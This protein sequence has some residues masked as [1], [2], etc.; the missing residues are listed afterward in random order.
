MEWAVTELDAW[1][2]DLKKNSTD[3]LT[4][5]FQLTEEQWVVHLLS[6]P[7][8][9][10]QPLPYTPS[11][12]RT[13]NTFHPRFTIPH[14]WTPGVCLRAPFRIVR[15]PIAVA[16]LPWAL[17]KLPPLDPPP[18][19]PPQQRHRVVWSAAMASM[20]PRL[21]IKQLKTCILGVRWCV[22]WDIVTGHIASV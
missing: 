11:T 4:S 22:I 16:E 15:L 21:F 14:P 1:V 17:E 7:P 2:A 20:N 10:D 5:V 9:P 3:A 12:A 13:V 19:P 18:L 8:Q 6:L